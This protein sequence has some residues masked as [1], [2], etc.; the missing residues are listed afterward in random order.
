MDIDYKEKPADGRTCSSSEGSECPQHVETQRCMS[1]VHV[2]AQRVG[3]TS[4]HENCRRRIE[5]ELKG[6]VKAEAAQM[7]LREY[8]DKAES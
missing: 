7:R 8:Q 2:V 5:E 6:T 1:R 4:A 3:E